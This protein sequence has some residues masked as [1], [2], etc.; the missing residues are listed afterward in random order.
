[1]LYLVATPIGNLQDITLRALEVLKICDYILCEDT[2]HSLRLL[3]HFNIK[4]SLKSYHEHNEQQ[5]TVEVIV[6]LKAGK[7]IALITDAGTPGISDPGTTLV[8]ACRLENLGVESIPGACAVITA[9]SASGLNTQRF[10]FMGFLPRKLS[11]L[12]QTLQEVLIYPGTTVFYESPQ[13]L[14]M[15]LGKIKELSPSRKLAVARELTKIHEEHL[16]GT[17]EELLRRWEGQT[18]KGEI[19]LMISSDEQEETISWEAF[20]PA[21]HVLFLEKTYQ[22]SRNDAIKLAAKMRGVSK[23]NIYKLFHRV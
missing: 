2:R 18:P 11:E 3:S 6:D 21:E 15:T 12:Q 7:K 19:V 4:K 10:Q 16:V 13:R 20:D 1:M 23:N 9:L 17:A 22:L 14:L 5:R 8:Q